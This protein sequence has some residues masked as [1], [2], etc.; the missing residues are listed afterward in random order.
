MWDLRPVFTVDAR[1]FLS[2]L[3]YFDLF[4]FVVFLFPP[5]E[6]PVKFDSKPTASK[7]CHC[8]FSFTRLIIIYLFIWIILQSIQMKSSN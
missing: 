7:M 4:L 5:E 8:A 3:S 1:N 6:A 2:L